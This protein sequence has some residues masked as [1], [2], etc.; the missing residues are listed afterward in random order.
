MATQMAPI[1]SP[2]QRLIRVFVSCGRSSGHCYPQLSEARAFG[3]AHPGVYPTGRGV[4][5]MVQ[6]G[7][8]G[9]A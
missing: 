9:G 4:K 1:S 3:G 2:Q 8:L 6:H 7:K 5:N